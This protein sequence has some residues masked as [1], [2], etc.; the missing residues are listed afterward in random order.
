MLKTIIFF[1]PILFISNGLLAQNVMM[2]DTL[3]FNHLEQEKGLLQLNVKDMAIDDL[4]YLWAGTEDGLHKFNSYKF[5]PYLHNPNDSTTIKD[6]HIRGLLFT[7]DTLWIAT[8]SK[9]I[10]GFIPSKNKF[11][12]PNISEKN[13]DINTSYKTLKINNKFLLFSL[14]NNIIIYDRDTKESQLRPLPISNTEN[15]VFDILQIDQNT[16]WLGTSSSGILTLNLTTLEIKQIPLLKD[17]SNLHFYKVDNDIYIGTKEGLF[18]YTDNGYDFF[19]RPVIF[20]K[21]IFGSKIKLAI[22]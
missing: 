4:G 12:S 17:N 22:I 11:F 19:G 6:D 10:T 8:N 2:Q 18:C 9:G 20:I 15:F 5:N 21:A 14:K 1:I 13:N 7:N 3:F 16:Y